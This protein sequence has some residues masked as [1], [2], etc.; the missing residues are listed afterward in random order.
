MKPRGQA[1]W[2]SMT[3]WGQGE[4]M[5]IR[6]PMVRSHPNCG[7]DEAKRAQAR[8]FEFGPALPRRVSLGRYG[9]S[10]QLRSFRLHQWNDRS[11]PGRSERAPAATSA[12]LPA[13]ST[14]SRE[15]PV[16][17]APVQ[18]QP[19]SMPAFLIAPTASGEVRNFRSA[20]APAGFL[21]WL[22]TPPEKTVISCM[23]SGRGPR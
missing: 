14:M 12:Q 2:D 7:S 15:E 22:C 21:A 17:R 10:S 20:A 8:A 6:P 1:A 11:S 16:I 18:S 13:Y 19:G 5:M 3:A 9:V 23:S 4:P